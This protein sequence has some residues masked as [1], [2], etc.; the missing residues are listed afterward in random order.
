MFQTVFR[1]EPEV[2]EVHVGSSQFLE[3]SW[4]SF[5]DFLKG[6]SD[7]ED[8]REL[9]ASIRYLVVAGDLVDGIGIYPD[10]EMELDILDVYDQYRKAAEYFKEVP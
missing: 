5:L 9:A 10:Q 1:E 6:E 7:S 4:L 2:M 3:D 8:M